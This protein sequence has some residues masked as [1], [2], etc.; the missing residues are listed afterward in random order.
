MPHLSLDLSSRLRRVLGRHE[1]MPFQLELA[2]PIL[3]RHSGVGDQAGLERLAALDSRMLPEG[4][5]LVAEIDGE[6]V[7][8]AP[9]DV[10]AEPVSDPF[11]PTANVR[12]LLRLQTRHVRRHRDAAPRPRRGRAPRTSRLGLSPS[13]E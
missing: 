9:I 5:F 6:L 8:A 3:I 11:R 13:R 1:R 2:S 12:E 10:D 7:A 4:S